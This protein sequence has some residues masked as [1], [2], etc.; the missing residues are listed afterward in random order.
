MGMSDMYTTLINPEQ[1]T[2]DEHTAGMQ[3]LIDDGMAWRLE[4][5]VGRHAH[6]LI[7]QG[8]CT[9]GPTSRT[10]FYGNTVPSRTQVQ[11]GSPGSA[12][13]VAKCTAERDGDSDQSDG[14]G[15]IEVRITVSRKRK[16]G[17]DV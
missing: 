14:G 10:D 17:K 4:G 3:E 1:Q 6:D 16:D 7:E 15:T 12:E 5:S 9:L 11:P 13:Y 2:P 8:Y